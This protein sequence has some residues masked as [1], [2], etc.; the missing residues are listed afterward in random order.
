MT[1]LYNEF[2]DFRLFDV[3]T[4]PNSDV[5]VTFNHKKK[6]HFQIKIQ[7]NIISREVYDTL[8][9]NS[10]TKETYPLSEDLDKNIIEFLTKYF[11][12]EI[13]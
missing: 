10:F 11:S 2:K 6:P 13:V 4:K 8:C 1:D 12:W 3:T 7:L 5:D 9:I